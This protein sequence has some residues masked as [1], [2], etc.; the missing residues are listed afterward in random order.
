MLCRTDPTRETPAHP[1]CRKT[2]KPRMCMG[3][4]R[5][6]PWSYRYYEI[7]GDHR[8][9][10]CWRYACGAH[11]HAPVYDKAVSRPP[12]RWQPTLARVVGDQAG[13]IDPQDRSGRRA[14]SVARKG[15][16]DSNRLAQGAMSHRT[17][18]DSSSTA[19][20]QGQS[21]SLVRPGDPDPWRGHLK[22]NALQQCLEGR[23]AAKL[24]E[25]R[26]VLHLHYPAGMLRAGLV[27]VR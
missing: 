10:C 18:W 7:S 1:T 27:Q 4:N 8:P 13:P 12:S 26:L 3:R 5:D 25:N 6:Q 14:R 22:S 21:A 23:L 9:A 15:V 2:P 11:N 19:I 20:K 24:P 17:F 16:L